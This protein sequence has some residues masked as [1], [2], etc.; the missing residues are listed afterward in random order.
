M[1][2]EHLTNGTPS[3]PYLPPF[4]VSGPG[5]VHGNVLV[6]IVVCLWN[7]LIGFEVG[8][9]C[10]I[11]LSSLSNYLLKVWSN[12]LIPGDQLLIRKMDLQTNNIW[13]LLVHV[14]MIDSPD[15]FT[16][17]HIASIKILFDLIQGL[18]SAPLIP[19]GIWWNKIWQE[20]LLFFFILV[21]FIPAE[22]GH[23]GIETR[24]FHGICRNRMQWNPVVCLFHTCYQTN[25]QPNT[26]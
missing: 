13:V 11:F 6:E 3:L 17:R 8:N 22:F 21:P 9:Q 4:F 25:H 19:A 26:V 18:I 24:M 5:K 23:S 12:M 2:I 15:S 20:G 14:K 7:L 10:G 1:S 16:G